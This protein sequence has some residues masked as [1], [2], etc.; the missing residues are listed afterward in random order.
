MLRL[1]VAAIVELHDTVA[2]PEPVTLRGLIAPQVRF[3]GT[4]SV[5]LTVPAKPLTAVTVIVEVAEVPTVTAAGDVA[6]IV[7]SLTVK[8]AVV[9]WERAP[10]VPVI[11]SV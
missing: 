6:A 9:E 10:L 2:V 4:L 8:V 5:R 1:Y 11:V 7:K 3:A